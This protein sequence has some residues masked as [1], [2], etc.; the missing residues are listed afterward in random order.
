M[1][2]N[3]IDHRNSLGLHAGD[4]VVV[5]SKEEILATLDREGRLDRLPFQPEMFAY[6]GQRL[7]VAKV[8]HKTCNN[9][10]KTIGRGRRMH[11]AV[12]LDGARCDGSRHGGCQADC[13]FFWKEAWLKRAD[14]RNADAVSGPGRGCAEQDVQRAVVAAGQEGAS[15]P[16]WVCQTTALLDATD[17][18]PWWKMSQ[19][20]R[21]VTS[22]N[23]RAWHMIK[24]MVAAVYRYIV[25]IGFG[26]R[27]LIGFYDWFQRMRG[28]KP[29]PRIT[30]QIAAGGQ[31]PTEILNLQ[32]GEWVE[33]KP[34]EEIAATLNARSY[35]RGMWYDIEMLKYSGGR[36][37]VQMRVDRLINEQTGK[38]MLMKSPCIQLEDVYCRA[39]CTDGRL[40]CPRASNT[41]WREIWLRR[42]SAPESGSGSR[43]V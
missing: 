1:P 5:R 13:V 4:W 23:Q 3:Y 32:P 8:A 12:H 34:K 43:A 11:N 33:I 22:G 2:V 35:N 31:T 28:G 9:I 25:G 6:C 10:D 37:R 27:Y 41:Y 38:M 36:Y 18:L 7:R 20:V 19:Y 40:G 21:D 42:V 29:F 17:P 24:L 14:A 30:G 15:D 26:Y 39:E 16:T